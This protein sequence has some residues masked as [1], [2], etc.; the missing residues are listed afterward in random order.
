MH[1]QVMVRGDTNQH[2]EPFLTP[3]SDPFVVMR[4]LQK[5]HQQWAEVTVVQ[6]ADHEHLASL[7][8][9][10]REQGPETGERS[11]TLGA[12][13][14]DAPIDVDQRRLALESGPGGDNDRPY[15][16]ELPENMAVLSRWLT[17]MVRHRHTPSSKDP[18]AQANAMHTDV[19][20]GD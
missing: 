14:A 19:N 12:T 5:A 7:V 9:R 16:F 13:R 8:E 15:T 17:L 10:V 3:E 20:S 11:V 18:G 1:F 6:A 4:L 2:W